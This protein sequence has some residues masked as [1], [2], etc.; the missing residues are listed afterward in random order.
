[1]VRADHNGTNRIL[2]TAA[3]V[4]LAPRAAIGVLI[5]AMV[6]LGAFLVLIRAA[7]IILQRF[8]A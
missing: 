5:L 4:Y 3:W 1:L 2:R 8:G 6:G 7:I